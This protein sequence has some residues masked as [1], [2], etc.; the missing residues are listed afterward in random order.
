VEHAA[1]IE[2]IWVEHAARIEWICKAF[3]VL[4]GKSKRKRPVRRSRRPL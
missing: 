4:G 3:K 1:R 2:W